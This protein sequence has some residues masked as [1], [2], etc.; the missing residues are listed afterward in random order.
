MT[1]SDP[2]PPRP[3]RRFRVA[4][5]IVG[6][7]LAY[8]AFG[9]LAAPPI[10]RRA[11]E[12]EGSAALRREV[13]VA[14]V[15]VN[16]LALSATL[17]GLTV[18]HADGAPL[19][20]W[21][22]L[23]VRLAPLRLFSGDVGL[24]EIRLVHPS[25]HVGLRSDGTLTFQDLL[26]PRPAEAAAGSGDAKK[27]GGLGLYIGKL[28]VEGAVVA[29]RD[30][31]RHP[32]FARTLGPLTIRLESFRTKGGGRDSPYAFSGT[33]D[34]G[35]TFRWT[36]TVGTQ[37]LHS[38]GAL[39]FE[40]IQLLKYAPYLQDEVPVDLRDGV[41]DFTTRYQVAWSSARRV[42][43]LEGGKVTLDRVAL[44][45]RGVAD[46]AVKLQ[47][48]E[49]TG[50]EV[51]ALAREATVRDVAVRGGALRV[52]RELGG[53]LELARMA[54]PPAPKP[55]EPWAWSVGAVAVSGLAVD[56]EDRVPATA[57]SL[58]LRDVGLRVERLRPGADAV[59]PIELSLSWN[60]RGRLA[61]AGSVQP[62]ARKGTLTLEAS[63]LDVAPL[64][65]YL[66][67]EV[68]LRIADGRAGAKARIAFDASGA[69]PSWTFAGDVRMDALALAE[70]GNDE[71]FRWR[72]LEISGIDAASAPP[73]A[74]VRLVRLVEPRAKAYIWEDGT[75]S[76]DRARR[77]PPTPAPARTRPSSTATPPWRV[78]IQAVQI[79]GGRAA[80]VD[81][82]V[83]PPAVLS[84][85]GFEGHVTSLSSDPRVRST[86]DARLQVEGASP[87][88]IAGTLNPL[89]K[90]AYTELTVSS[91]GVDLSPLDPYSGKFLGYGI[92]KGKLDLD[93][94]YRIQDRNLAATNVVRVN[95]FTLGERTDSADA[96]KIP[97]RLALALLQDKDGIILL[98]VPVEG[99]LDDPDFH[100]GKVIWRTVLNVLVKVATSPFR[101][102]AALVGSGEQADLSVADFAPGT[103]DALPAANER[104]ALLAK[105]LGQR[106]AL[107]L[108]LEGSADLEQ[109]GPVLRRAEL[110][111]SLR[112]AK[113]AALHPP[114]TSPDGVTLTP[115]ERAHLVRAAYEAAFPAVAPS[116]RP[117]DATP[118]AP[119]AVRGTA[120]PPAPHEMEERLAAAVLIPADALRTLAAERAQRARDAL[121]GA[122]VDQARLFLVQGGDRAAKEK[123]ARVYFTVR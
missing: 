104:I 76:L 116:S 24:A 65:P 26:A 67:P 33:T 4:A 64:A 51:D 6:L 44:G 23:Y 105:S 86:V 66:E 50:I 106:P 12:K 109:D 15:R 122:G 1:P 87:V 91:L 54:P 89:Q 63:D 74:K 84:V 82:S 97:V 46:P 114:A 40:R 61:V 43:R 8:T 7:A 58:P 29:F 13:T 79:A 11:L 17:E 100:L 117:A 118:P 21:D 3:R 93:L 94:R 59:W 22:S 37:P 19:A 49:V 101:A 75:T 25:V 119:G 88:R 95:Q 77:A 20:S 34:S 5:V 32:A 107:A 39:E 62:F 36:G 71:L 103:A 10:L 52:V 47:R 112:R 123:G 38:T 70:R 98:D 35:E 78:A 18:R 96:T 73:H 81:R 72:A 16:P 27:G 110:E 48:V 42:L 115:D 85:S 83:R 108:E 99:R 55:G 121:V 102:L 41:L 45:P 68:S 9:F 80:F 120:T 60:G 56:L 31:T 92:Q 90:D 30:E 111:R 14:R 28:S 69:A 53:G 2:V 113:A 57:V